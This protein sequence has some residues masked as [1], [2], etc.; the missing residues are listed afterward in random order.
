MYD[1][2]IFSLSCVLFFHSFN[3]F[4]FW[5]SIIYQFF[6]CGS[7][8]M[9]YPR[10]LSVLK[11]HKNNLLY[12]LPE[13]FLSIRLYSWIVHLW[14]IFVC[15]A[16]CLPNFLLLKHVYQYMQL[17]RQDLS[18]DYPFGTELF[19][20]FSWKGIN[21]YMSLILDYAFYPIDPYLYTN[22]ILSRLIMVL[23]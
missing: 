6:P 13:V 12:F 9:V 17:F 21:L 10:N 7:H 20:Y 19:L 14:L 11:G 22:T 4:K 23:Y 5:W 3:S 18:K 8:F 2:E 16:R 15:I 1:L